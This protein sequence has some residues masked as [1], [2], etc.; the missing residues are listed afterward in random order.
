MGKFKS[1]IQQGVEANVKY[2]GQT[3]AAILN[4][5]QLENQILNKE[6]SPVYL[7]HG[8]ENYFIDKAIQLVDK[9]SLPEEEKSFRFIWKEC[10]P[11]D[12]LPE[13]TF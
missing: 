13:K 1:I 5:Q 4:Y 9:H 2:V 12:K 6:F 7:F 10:S 3:A 11:F 8:T